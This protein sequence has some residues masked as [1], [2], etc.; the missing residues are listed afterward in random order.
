VGKWIA[1][2][3]AERSTAERALGQATDGQRLTKD[4]VRALV[5]ALGDTVAALRQ[6]DPVDKADAYRELGINLTFHP[7][8][9]VKVE[10]RPRVYSG[11]CRRGDLNPHVLL[12]H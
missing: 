10:A 5:A 12:G 7:E 3:Q 8:G 2:V 1:E 6:A 9:T 4:E 11:V